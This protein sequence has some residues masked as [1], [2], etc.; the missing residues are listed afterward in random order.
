VKRCI[1]WIKKERFD[2]DRR[3]G[4][5]IAELL[6][7]LINDAVKENRAKIELLI[8]ALHQH[9]SSLLT[10]KSRYF[11]GVYHIES[12]LMAEYV[13]I[14]EA[15]VLIYPEI[16]SYLWHSEKERRLAVHLKNAMINVGKRQLSTDKDSLELEVTAW[17]EIRENDEISGFWQDTKRKY[18][19]GNLDS[20]D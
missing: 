13:L 15:N 12:M 7:K 6:Y 16:D 5:G 9:V 17:K 14:A 3:N 1:D 11:K 20:L 19:S 2:G 10:S 8:S 4:D 18:A